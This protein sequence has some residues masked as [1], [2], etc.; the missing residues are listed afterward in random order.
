MLYPKL[1][2]WIVFNQLFF[3]SLI[4]KGNTTLLNTE[5]PP[6]PSENVIS[7]RTHNNRVALKPVYASTGKYYRVKNNHPNIACFT[8][9]ER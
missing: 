6:T 5:S 9:I 4:E 3:F 1:P 7:E 8:F 2:T